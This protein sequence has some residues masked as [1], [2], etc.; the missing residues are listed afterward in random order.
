MLLAH[1]GVT[2]GE[3]ELI[4]KTQL[5]EG[6]LTPEELAS[7]SRVWGL[8]ASERRLDDKELANLVVM[9]RFPIVYLYR[10]FL[11]GENS[12]HAVI[13]VRISRSFVTLL[14][15]LRGKRRVSIRK[16]ARGRAMVQQ[17]AVVVD[18]S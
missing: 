14:D 4:K 7:L 2:V 17:W 15:P 5:D 11:D 18:E 8:P 1:R 3:D 16:F 13:P 12:V 6:G 9:G 10:K